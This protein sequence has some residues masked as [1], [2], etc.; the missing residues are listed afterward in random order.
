M[1]GLARAAEY[2]GMY[3]WSKTKKKKA[4]RLG[5]FLGSYETRQFEN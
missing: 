1:D 5:A 3:R 4:S 2:R